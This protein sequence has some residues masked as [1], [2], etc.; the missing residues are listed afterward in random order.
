MI[1]L[2]KSITFYEKCRSFLSVNKTF[3]EDIPIGIKICQ[4]NALIQAGDSD[5]EMS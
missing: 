4:V 3:P 2:E 5:N 1:Q